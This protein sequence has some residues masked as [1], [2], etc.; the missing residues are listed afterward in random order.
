VLENGVL[1]PAT[2]VIGVSANLS[3]AT[4]TLHFAARTVGGGG[5]GSSDI[6]G[7]SSSSSSWVIS[8][9]VNHTKGEWGSHTFP[10]R[11]PA[12]TGGTLEVGL[13]LM[14]QSQEEEEGEEEGQ[15]VTSMEAGE[16]EGLLLGTLAEFTLRRLGAARSG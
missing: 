4:C 7:G 16:E 10:Y 5:G 15:L 8:H 1:M 12:Q 2:V 11:L 14:V 9:G 13:I 6:G 3:C